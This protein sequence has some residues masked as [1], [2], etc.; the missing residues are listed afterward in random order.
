MNKATNANLILFNKLKGLASS[1]MCPE[2][3]A[4]RISGEGRS[5]GRIKTKTPRHCAGAFGLER[6]LNR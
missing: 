1:V 2:M 5:A 4:I 3:F 6:D